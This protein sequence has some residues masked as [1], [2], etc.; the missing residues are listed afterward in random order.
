M[1]DFP[2]FC[3]ERTYR[4]ARLRRRAYRSLI[5]GLGDSPTTRESKTCN[6]LAHGV[7]NCVCNHDVADCE[8]RMS[9]PLQSLWPPYGVSISCGPVTLTAVRDDDFPELTELIRAGIHPSEEMPFLDPWTVGTTDEVSRRFLQHQWSIRGLMSP[10][11][12][13]FETVIRVED[14]IT[15]CQGLSATRFPDTRSC[16]T[17]SWIGHEHQRA[18]IGT[19]ARQAMCT[20]A[21]DNLGAT[22]ISSAAFADNPASI[23]VSHKIGYRACG[24]VEMLTATGRMTV[25]RVFTL[26]PDALV[27][28]QYPVVV[29]GCDAFKGMLELR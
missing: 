23:A 28:P 26:T 7:P 17:S 25:R 19:L 24:T 22:E 13:T 27:R 9:H 16:E 12:W 14:R 29:T 11:A 3:S 1:S 4:S 20:F 8:E 6:F 2:Q 5:G 15:G 21:F 10:R 18:G